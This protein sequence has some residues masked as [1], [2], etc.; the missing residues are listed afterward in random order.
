MVKIF[1]IFFIVKN[2][3]FP[4]RNLIANPFK[5]LYNQHME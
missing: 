1:L 5:I 2:K 3:T 4:I